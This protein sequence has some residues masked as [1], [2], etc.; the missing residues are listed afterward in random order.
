MKKLLCALCVSLGLT[1]F[2]YADNIPMCPIIPNVPI[3]QFFSQNFTESTPV[4]INFPCYLID[5]NFKV[6]PTY[7]DTPATSDGVNILQFNIYS[8]TRSSI[9]LAFT[10]NIPEAYPNGVTPSFMIIHPAYTPPQVR[11]LKLRHI[12]K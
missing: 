1:S 10:Y 4:T 6:L 11:E 2:T 9:T 5:N 8:I 3:I 7:T 12:I